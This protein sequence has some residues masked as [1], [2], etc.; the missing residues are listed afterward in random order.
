[1]NT[2]LKNKFCGTKTETDDDKVDGTSELDPK[3]NPKVKGN[4][5]TFDFLF[6]GLYILNY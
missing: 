6:I 5:Y 1:M 4:R 3:V 2:F